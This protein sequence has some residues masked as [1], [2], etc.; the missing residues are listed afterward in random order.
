MDPRMPTEGVGHI[1]GAQHNSCR[2]DLLLPHPHFPAEEVLQMGPPL[3]YVTASQLLM[4]EW[5][6]L[7]QR[8]PRATTCQGWHSE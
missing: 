1:T 7:M 3:A 2:Y 8:V 5:C 6:I 4:A